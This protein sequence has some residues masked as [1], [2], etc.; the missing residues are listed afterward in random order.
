MDHHNF[1]VENGVHALYLT[2]MEGTVGVYGGPLPVR[3]NLSRAI[4]RFGRF[5]KR[6][7]EHQIDD[8]LHVAELQLLLSSRKPTPTSCLYENAGVAVMSI[9]FRETTDNNPHLEPLV[10]STRQVRGVW[11][12]RAQISVRPSYLM[13]WQAQSYYVYTGSLTFPPCTSNIPTLV[14]ARPV[15]IGEEQMNTLRSNMYVSLNYCTYH[16]AGQLRASFETHGRSVYRSFKYFSSSGGGVNVRSIRC[17][18][19]LLIVSMLLAHAF[20][21]AA[22]LLPVSIGSSTDGTLVATRLR[23]G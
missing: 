11:G 8:E 19:Q 13:P 10:Q 20:A 17:P 7:S 21:R 18:G 12:A 3:Y 2:L 6:G 4:L 14:F 15:L 5:T 23:S 22:L 1:T 9:L 16:L